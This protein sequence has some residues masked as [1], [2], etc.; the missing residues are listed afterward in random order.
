MDSS[1]IASAISF[2][3]AGL[4][5]FIGLPDSHGLSPRFLRFEA[6][7]VLYPPVILVFLAIGAANLISAFAAQ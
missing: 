2:A 3:A 5:F 6:A 7:P 1:L 4:L